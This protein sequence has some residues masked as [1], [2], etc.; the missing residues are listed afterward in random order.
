MTSPC[1]S[2]VVRQTY[3][4]D[5]AAPNSASGTRLLEREACLIPRRAMLVRGDRGRPTRHCTLLGDPSASEPGGGIACWRPTIP[6]L[7][8]GSGETPRAVGGPS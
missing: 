6:L 7:R 5:W 4:S 2:V 3:Q 8:A 1:R